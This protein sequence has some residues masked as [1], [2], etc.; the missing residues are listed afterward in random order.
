MA[1]EIRLVF[2]LPGPPEANLAAWKATPPPF[3]ADY[4]L[5]DE[6]Y[7]TL[8]YEAQVMGAGMRILM[9][10]QA[11]TL[12]RLMITF[13]DDATVGTRVMLN[14]QAKDDVR[15]QIGAYLRQHTQ[16]L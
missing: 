7:E 10:G 13:T 16:A 5:K 9:W 6:A 11:K 4:H 14:G 15:D 8:V 1:D 3:L 2:G 12:Y